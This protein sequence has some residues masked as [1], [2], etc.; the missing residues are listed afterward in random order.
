MTYMMSTRDVRVLFRILPE[1]RR[2]GWPMMR[3]QNIRD[4]VPRRQHTQTIPT[5][6]DIHT[7]GMMRWAMVDM[8]RL[9]SILLF[10]Y[11]LTFIL[12]PLL[13]EERFP[14]PLDYC[15]NP[16]G[17]SLYYFLGLCSNKFMSK[18]F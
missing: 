13:W 3:R 9:Y 18:L 15:N 17:A 1:D 10:I 2:L 5:V 6:L 7:E 4:M 8:L 16:M 12:L 11:S 14:L